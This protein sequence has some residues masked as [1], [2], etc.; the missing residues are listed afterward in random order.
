MGRGDFLPIPPPRVLENVLGLSEEQLGQ[1]KSLLE[2][3]KETVS[4]FRE[5]LRDLHEAVRSELDSENPDAAT[6]G[7]LVI[8]SH[9]TQALIKSATEA[10]ID[11][12][13]SI[14][15]AEQL[16]R[17]EEWKSRRGGRRRPRG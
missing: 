11:E 5:Q 12:F 17:F 13:E 15:T 3:H 2:G 7:G 9:A 16:E 14:L 4:T 1:V 10:L 6:V 8:E